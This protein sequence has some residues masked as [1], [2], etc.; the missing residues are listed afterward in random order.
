MQIVCANCTG[1]AFRVSKEKS[2]GLTVE[3]IRC[4][5]KAA[6]HVPKKSGLNIVQLVVPERR[7]TAVK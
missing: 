4:A 3:C 5:V 6:I 7:P 1:N 2:G